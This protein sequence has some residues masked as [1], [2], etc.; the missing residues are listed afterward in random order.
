MWK[1]KDSLRGLDALIIDEISMVSGEMLDHLSRM[2]K[3][4]RENNTAFGG[5]QLIF[6]G[7]FCQLPPI[8]DRNFN[9][10]TKWY[11]GN[12]G[13]AFQSVLWK[14][15]NF[16]IIILTKSMRQ[17]DLRF[18]NILNKIR[19]GKHLGEEE[20]TFLNKCTTNNVSRP[21]RLYCKNK[22]VDLINQNELN[23][24][25]TPA[26]EYLCED[27]EMVKDSASQKQRRYFKQVKND[28]YNRSPQCSDEI[29]LKVGAEVMCTANL[30]TDLCNGTRG[31]V[32]GMQPKEVKLQEL[33]NEASMLSPKTA[34]TFKKQQEI[35]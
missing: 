13:F 22:N 33:L 6:C 20:L 2:M 27:G 12:R 28:Y 7:D 26:T 8:P 25:K 1:N 17:K 32:V 34:N 31:I 14:E 9:P 19:Y 15:A 5:V 16:E 24:L 30:T 21:T 18:F 3:S 10:E 29:E 4:I 23:K 11:F 35:K